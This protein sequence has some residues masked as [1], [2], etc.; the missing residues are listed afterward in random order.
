MSEK[1]IIAENS[2]NGFIYVND[3]NI[4]L[5]V[6]KNEDFVPPN[7]EKYLTDLQSA[8][9]KDLSNLILV[10][11]NALFFLSGNQHIK[12]RKKIMN[13]LGKVSIQKWIPA[14][15]Q[16]IARALLNL[17]Q[18]SSPDIVHDFTYPIFLETT[19][20]VLGIKPED[21]LEFDFWTQQLQ[22][23]LQPLLPLRKLM[24]MESALGDLLNQIRKSN[25]SNFQG[26]PKSLLQ[27]LKSFNLENYTEDD[28]LATILVIYGASINISQTLAN[29]VWHI[30]SAPEQ[31]RLN[32]K[33]PVWIKN[34][35]EYLIKVGASPRYIHS[36]SLKDIQIGEQNFMKG[37][38]VLID[39]L[40]IHQVGCP[41]SKQKTWDKAEL[42]KNTHIAF[43]K[44]AHFCVGAF[45]SRVLIE[46]AIPQLFANFPNLTIM[47]GPPDIGSN[48]QTVFLKSL[49]VL[50][51]K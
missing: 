40:E 12:L 35:L 33:D 36:I 39:L 25:E 28:A 16:A 49:K 4:A 18:S 17:K 46:R 51:N 43:G 44:G 2:H 48:K 8:T 10:S 3:I 1:L 24:K 13:S 22:T 14:F 5:E 9:G 32:A 23:L 19:Q 30:L 15:D 21:P 11:K 37:D 50:N 45:Q 6:N 31:I 38:N 47:T 20:K 29:I 7:M 34:N 42:S 26:S 41:F 27:E